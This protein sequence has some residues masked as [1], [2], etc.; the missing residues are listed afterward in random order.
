MSEGKM[1]ILE[2]FLESIP[3]KNTKAS[4]QRGLVMFLEYIKK[5]LEE[6]IE[7]R[8]QE[9]TLTPNESIV[10]QKQRSNK[11]EREILEPFYLDM[12]KRDYKPNTAAKNC[13]GILR[14]LAYYSMPIKLRNGSP[15]LDGKKEIGMSRFP[16]KIDHV[17]QMFWKEKKLIYKLALSLAID[18]PAR[19]EDFL[20]IEIAE[21]PDL[22][23]P[24]PIEFM[25]MSTKEHQ[26]QKSC[27]SA[28]TVQLMKE[29]ISVFTPKKYL[30]ENG[31]TLPLSG[32]SLNNEL[33]LLAREC[34][35]QTKPYSITF[36]CF[37]DLVL[38]T[39]KSLDID[40]DSLRL[41]TGK[42]VSRA[43]LP[44]LKTLDIKKPFEKLQEVLHINGA[45][46]LPQNSDMITMLGLE[47]KALKDE[48]EN[49]KIRL[50]EQLGLMK[51]Y[52]DD[53]TSYMIKRE[54]TIVGRIEALE[55]ELRAKKESE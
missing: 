22:E 40:E 34:N 17:R 5:P 30:F 23:Q 9:L 45:L 52:L 29:Y 31:N 1:S 53:K 20:S 21:L 38:S 13:D 14:L 41:I 48:N 49:L 27:L 2:Q 6:V 50:A 43:V 4:Y 25:R 12:L 51:E 10:D 47:V 46:L 39:G 33:K 28:L 11:F 54:K 32:D 16:L 3:N 26:L 7:Q 19:I 15:I 8:K 36:H 44:Y 18:F 42:A 35:I 55:K 24:A 37:R